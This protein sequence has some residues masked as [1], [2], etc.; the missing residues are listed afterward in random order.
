MVTGDLPQAA[1]GRAGPTGR[2]RV[3][4]VMLLIMFALSVMAYVQRT[5]IGVAADRMMPELGLTTVDLGW[6]Q[7]AFL[8]SYTAFQIPGGIVGELIG[9]R[10]CLFFM[11]LLA[12]AASFA[13]ALLPALMT[14]AALMAGLLATR[15]VLGISHGPIFPVTAGVNEAWF[16][17]KQWSFAMGFLS[18]GLNVG[19]AVAQPLVATV[20]AASNWQTALIVSSAPML[21]VVAIWGWYGRDRATEHWAVSAEELDELCRDP[22]SH[23]RPIVTLRQTLRLLANREILL[24]SLSYLLMNYVFYLLTFW[25]FL[26]LVQERHFSVLESGFLAA[27]PYLAAAAGAGFGG[28]WSDLL[29]NRYGAAWGYRL[30][31]L[32]ALPITGLALI[33]TVEASGAFWAIFGLCLAFFAVETTEGPYWAATTEVAQT[34]TTIATG[35]L[36]TG[37]NLGGVIFTPLVGWLA[38]N[39]D[40][41]A[42][43]MTGAACSLVAA[44]LW[45]LVDARRKFISTVADDDIAQVMA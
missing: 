38:E 8:V 31:P 19:S 6:L 41:G 26:Y 9:A 42:A 25:V 45:L 4:W 23:G 24:L 10:R 16:P 5:G 15:F 32:A 29:R 13:T 36:N 21:L 34:D 22:E 27:L 2:L 1:L 40:W 35:V 39:G 3:R 44:A 20:M 28:H 17:A 30:L 14:G 12:V 43:F 7:T 33:L 11:G 18:S 37:G